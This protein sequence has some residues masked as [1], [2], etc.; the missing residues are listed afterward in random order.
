MLRPCYG[1]IAELGR[2][3]TIA[4]LGNV[5]GHCWWKLRTTCRREPFG[6]T[7]QAFLAVTRPRTKKGAAVRVLPPQTRVNE[8]F[9]S[10]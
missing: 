8:V 9:D 2:I 5:Q 7:H 4:T 3:D 10:S 6:I 1:P